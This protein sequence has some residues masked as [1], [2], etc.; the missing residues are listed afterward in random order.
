MQDIGALRE[1]IDSIMNPSPVFMFLRN[2][3]GKCAVPGCRRFSGQKRA[4]R[5]RILCKR[6]QKS[7][8]FQY[9]TQ[10]V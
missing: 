7:V 10:R 9:L 5:R 6:H 1:L 8:K 3:Y 4:G 2:G